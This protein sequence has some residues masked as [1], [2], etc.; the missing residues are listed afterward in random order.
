MRL[1]TKRLL[2][3]EFRDDD[4]AAVSAYHNNPLYLRYYPQTEETAVQSRAFVQMFL[5]QQAATPRTKFQLAI[6]LKEND[7]LIGNCG[8]RQ[9]TAD[10][11]VGDIGYEL[12]PTYWGQGYAT[13]AARVILEFGFCE[14]KLHRISA[15]CI[16]D[17]VGSV[18]VLQKLGM[19]QEGRL[20]E[21]LFFKD[22]WW[23]TLIFGVLDYEW[24][25]QQKGD[26]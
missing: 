20:R 1:T 9:Q 10:S 12:D 18:R 24:Q 13:E 2:L 25:A 8:V 7:K 19:R 17:N 5:E 21:N 3:R 14:R 6:T 4:W 11:V 26:K 15:E 23:D 16:A 22:R